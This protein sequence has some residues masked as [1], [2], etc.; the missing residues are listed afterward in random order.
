MKKID[1]AQALTVLANVGVI[2]GI[3]FLATE[4]R[5]N[6]RAIQ[7]QTRDSITE[8][9]MQ[10]YS[11]Q[12]TNFELAAVISKARDEGFEA[13]DRVERQMFFGYMEAFFREHENAVY[14]FDQG[15]FSAEEFSGRVQNMRDILSVP[16][17]RGFWYGRQDRYS[18]S[19]R[20]EIDSILAELEYQD[21]E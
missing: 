10:L 5:L 15:L 18:P 19:L 14:Q 21:T 1:V 12:A 13:L 8:K 9:E 11:W 6:T 2:A 4:L 17:F 3:V 20:A 7:A 16:A